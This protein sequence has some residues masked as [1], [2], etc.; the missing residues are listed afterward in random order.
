MFFERFKPKQIWVS[1]AWRK[2]PESKVP[3]VAFVGRSNVGKS[4]LINA[5]AGEDI[6]KTGPRPGK[7]REMRAYGLTGAKKDGGAGKGGEMG[8][9]ITLLDMPGYGFASVSD[10]GQSILK[11]LQRRTQLRKVYVLLNAEHSMKK[12]DFEMLEL[13]KSMA[14]PYQIILTKTDELT[15][16]KGRR[17][18]FDRDSDSSKRINATI[19][20]LRETLRGQSVKDEALPDQQGQVGHGD[21]LVSGISSSRNNKLWA[22]HVDEIRWAIL[23]ATGFDN[24]GVHIKELGPESEAPKL[25]WTAQRPSLGETGAKTHNILVENTKDPS[26]VQSDSP[27][28]DS[29]PSIVEGDRRHGEPVAVTDETT[30][31]HGFEPFFKDEV[32]SNNA[33]RAKRSERS[34]RPLSTIPGSQDMEATQITDSAI[35][36]LWEMQDSSLGKRSRPSFGSRIKSRSEKSQPRTLLLRKRKAPRFAKILSDMDGHQPSPS[37]PPEQDSQ[38]RD[39]D[40]LSEAGES[41]ARSEHDSPLSSRLTSVEALLSIPNASS[42]IASTPKTPSDQDLPAQPRPNA[43]NPSPNTSATADP[44]IT[45]SQTKSKSG[46]QEVRQA[47]SQTVRQEQKTDS[48]SQGDT[49]LEKLEDLIRY[50]VPGQ[51]GSP[52]YSPEKYDP[53]V[54]GL[55]GLEALSAETATRKAGLVDAPAEHLTSRSASATAAP[56]KST[57]GRSTASSDT[58]P[59]R[60]GKGR[61]PS[62]SRLNPSKERYFERRRLRRLAAMFEARHTQPWKDDKG[63]KGTDLGTSQERLPETS[64][65]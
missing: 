7:T 48:S 21:I 9:K 60:P 8:F 32:T 39:A 5:I 44:T 35:A 18:V 11:Y 45:N 54:G 63:K 14:I 38:N 51:K 23:Q 52:S 26:T 2:V 20:A 57:A 16:D 65:T 1:D 59:A 49:A 64:K 58:A 43:S 42:R 53:Q 47:E 24:Y 4:S 28:D 55:S 41:Q 30:A 15:K 10:W 56:F 17:V 62:R 25:D 12:V 37:R 46:S 27:V 3:E 29:S 22:T 34:E 6:C 31:K 50:L 19:E 36:S 40:L 33:P 61:S 13:L